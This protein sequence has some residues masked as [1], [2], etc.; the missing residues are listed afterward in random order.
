MEP[1]S[2]HSNLGVSRRKHAVL[3]YVRL[4]KTQSSVLVDVY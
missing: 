1:F 4:V 2:E 3:V